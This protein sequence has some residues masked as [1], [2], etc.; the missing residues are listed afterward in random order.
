MEQFFLGDATS[1]MKHISGEGHLGFTSGRSCLTNMI[2]LY[3]KVTCLVSVRQV[4]DVVHMDF[5]K[6]FNTDCQSY[7]LEKLICYSQDR[8][9]ARWVGN[10]LPGCTQE[11]V[12]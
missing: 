12:I 6:A 8:W 11:V 5:S 4:V 7:Q 10:W 9:S 1:E 2:V 3:N